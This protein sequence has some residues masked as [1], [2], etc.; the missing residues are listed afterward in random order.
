MICFRVDLHKNHLLLVVGIWAWSI[1]VRS[2]GC[3]LNGTVTAGICVSG[4]RLNHCFQSNV[5]EPTAL[6]FRALKV[7]NSASLPARVSRRPRPTCVKAKVENKREQCSRFAHVLRDIDENSPVT[8]TESSRAV[9]RRSTRLTPL[10]PQRSL[11]CDSASGRNESVSCR[12]LECWP[13]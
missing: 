6:V 9:T 11:G 8:R 10:R 12:S 3:Y 2:D 7:E 5:R 13:Q 1:P 4:G